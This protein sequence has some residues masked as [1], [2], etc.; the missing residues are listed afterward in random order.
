MP[1]LRRENG[2]TYFHFSNE[3]DPR[4]PVHVHVRKGGAIAKIWL[5][6]EVALQ[7]SMGF[8]AGELRTIMKV[9]ELRQ[10]QFVEAWNDHFS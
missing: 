9:V 3:G 2:F 10:Q 8:N 7:D 1:V 4:E 6:P 5:E